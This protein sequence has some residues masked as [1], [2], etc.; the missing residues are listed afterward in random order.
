MK[1]N[2]KNT[3]VWT[4]LNRFFGVAGFLAAIVAIVGFYYQ[5][6]PKKSEIQFSLISKDFLTVKNNIKGL[7]SNYT[8]AG[9][10]VNNLWL[11]KFKIINTG[12]LP[13]YGTNQNSNLLDSCITFKFDSNIEILNNLKLIQNNLPSHKIYKSTKNRLHLTFQ[14]WRPN[15]FAIYSIYVKSNKT[16]P[17]FLPTSTR[18]LK[19]GDIVIEN[20]LSQRIH[21]A[22]PVIDSWFDKPIPLIGRILGIFFC[23][24][25][26][27]AICAF[28]FYIMLPE[29]VKYRYWIR[30]YGKT[31]NTFIINYDDARIKNERSKLIFV[32]TRKQ[33]ANNPSTLSD[34]VVLNDWKNL[35]HPTIPDTGNSGSTWRNFILILSLIIVLIICSIS[36]VLG[37]WMN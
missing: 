18:V 26:T 10:P 9:E 35:N 8:Y 15:E 7:E 23:S 16:N 33:I 21:L 34:H 6:Q 28:L 25:I 20:L 30:K 11:I 14:Q 31:F 4:K 17:S 22:E 24:L 13:L 29:W 2:I 12:D 19:D 3:G 32:S 37:L 27:I 36:C 5:F 1:Q